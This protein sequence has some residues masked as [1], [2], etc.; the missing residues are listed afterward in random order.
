[1][2][3]SELVTIASGS[4]AV[5]LPFI[6]AAYFILNNNQGDING[7]SSPNPCVDFY[8]FACNKWMKENPLLTESDS[9]TTFTQAQLNIDKFLWKLV[10]DDSYSSNDPRLQAASKFYKSC[11]N[12]RTSDTFIS[13]CRQWIYMYFGQWGLMPPTQQIDGAPNIEN[14]DLTDF[15]LPAIM[16]FGYSLLFSL[17]ID[18]RARSIKISPGSL[19]FDLTTDEAQCKKNKEDF[20]KT[21]NVLRIPKS[22]E[23]ELDI[24]F[25]LMRKLSRIDDPKSLQYQES[26]RNTT[27]KELRSICPEIRWSDLFVKVFTEA[28]YEDYE[29][30]PITIEGEEQLKQRC[31]Q[32]ELALQT[33]RKAFETMMIIN[34]MDE[35]LKNVILPTT[36]ETDNSFTSP[37]QS[38]FDVDC[39]NQLKAA[40]AYTLAK[41]YLS[42]HVNETHKKEITTM[43][44]EVKK[45]VL[46][47]IPEYNWLTDDLKNFLSNKIKNVKIHALYTNLS[48]SEEKENN[49]AIYRY[50]IE[51]GNYYWN[52][53]QIFKAK[54]IDEMKSNLFPCYESLSPLPS[55]TPSVYYQKEENRVYVSAELIQ[56]PYYSDENDTSSKFGSMGFVLSHEL[57]HSIDI[58]GVSY[59]ANGKTPDQTIYLT[60]LSLIYFH[61]DCFRQQYGRDETTKHKIERPEV[62]GEIIADNGG[63]TMSF[64]TYKELQTKHA[65]HV[66]Q[67]PN[68][69]HRLDQLFFLKFAKI[70]C[71]H[72]RGKA[73][74]EFAK[75]SPYVLER[76]RVNTALSNSNDFAKAYSCALGSP[77]NP[78]KKC[79]VY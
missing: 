55:F 77:M 12:Y 34:F 74:E 75:D 62:L 6:F 69:T 2:V 22:H 3:I 33:D 36:S 70:M 29:R 60:L 53:F 39:L 52:L 63:I 64:K 61:T 68:A 20:Y 17:A 51:E 46:K 79:K 35:Q 48:D 25:Q 42:S 66:S 11:T 28:E 41:Y 27:L 78:L 18:P 76:N 54:H 14:M 49:S 37:S 13:A 7:S 57:L 9:K 38:R 67:D 16:Q 23:T 26:N 8:E 31:K 30:L 56:P 58:I 65:S 45:T 71:G 73:L 59:D 43:F 24:A 72:H 21:A 4:I 44:E 32:H 1:M 10:T 5:A 47:S 15:C 40:Y 50:T 19:W